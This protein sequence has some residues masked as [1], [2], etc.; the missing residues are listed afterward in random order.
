MD[1]VTFENSV[2]PKNL[3]TRGALYIE[4]VL[5]EIRWEIYTFLLSRESQTNDFDLTKY[6]TKVGDID[7]IKPIFESLR[8]VGWNCDLSYGDTSL[9]IYRGEKPK[10]C[11]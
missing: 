6:I 3:K 7:H 11:W 2:S 9:F 8:K 4:V 1:A 5:D 10:N